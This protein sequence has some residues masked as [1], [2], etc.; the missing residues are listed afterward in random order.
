VTVT[1]DHYRSVA[2]IMPIPAAVEST[3]MRVEFGAG[4]TI[5]IP[6]IIPVASDPEA[7]T[8]CTRDCRR[9]DRQGRQ[10]SENVGNFLHA[11]API[12][13]APEENGWGWA[14]FPELLGTAMKYWARFPIR[15]NLVNR[16]GV[17]G[18]GFEAPAQHQRKPQI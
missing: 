10:R 7:E 11:G 18:A 4:T 12:V 5:V 9:R 8:L 17:D 2:V 14:T 1:P 6:V 16:R 3:V 15:N 13:I